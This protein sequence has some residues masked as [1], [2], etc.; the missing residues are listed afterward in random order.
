MNFYNYNFEKKTEELINNIVDWNILSNY[1][2]ETKNENIDNNLKVLFFY[3][4]FLISTL[5]LYMKTFKNCIF[6]KSIYDVKM[7]LHYNPNYVFE[8]RVERFLNK[9]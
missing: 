2:I 5:I 1:I 4:S 8:Y 7:I 6:I 9:V 3:D